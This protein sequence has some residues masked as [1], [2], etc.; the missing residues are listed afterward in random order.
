MP[1]FWSHP[2]AFDGLICPQPREF[3]PEGAWALLELTDALH[4]SVPV[5]IG[6]LVTRLAKVIPLG[7][8]FKKLSRKVHLLSGP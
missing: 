6:S 7:L 5:L 3:A 4:V 1:S 8:G 2:Q